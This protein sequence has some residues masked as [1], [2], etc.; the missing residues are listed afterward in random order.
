M[1]GSTLCGCRT[2]LLVY[3]AFTR[4]CRCW[5]YGPVFVCS[6]TP[7]RRNQ[8]PI[9]MAIENRVALW[10]HLPVVYQEDMQVGE[11]FSTLCSGCTASD[12]ASRAVC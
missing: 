5:H 8:D 7:F 3:V 6:L 10:T 4:R 2:A 1:R 9:I 12:F 11:A